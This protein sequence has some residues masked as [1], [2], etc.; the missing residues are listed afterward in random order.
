M[1]VKKIYPRLIKPPQSSFFLFGP[2]GIGKSTWAKGQFLGAHQFDLL[3]EGLYQ[4]LLG[5]PS[6]FGAELSTLPQQSWVIVDEIQRLP[7]LLNLV[8]LY[9]EER[10]LQFILLGSSARN[11]KTAGTN[12]L[13]GRAL[14]KMMFPL[15]PEEL[16]DDFSLEEIF[17]F[18]AIPL[19]W[20][21]PS[22]AETLKSY[23]QLYLKEEIQA[24]ALVRNLPGFTRFLSIAA[25]F[26]G[27]LINIAGIAR[28]SGTAR[29]TVSGFLDILDDTLLTF[30]LPAFV[31]KLKVREKKHP[32]LYWV[33][34]GLV[35]AIK[36]QLGP[37]AL[38]ERGPLLE[39][40]ILGLLRVYGEE[41]N[42][43][44]EIYYWSSAHATGHEVDFLLQRD[45]EYLAI[46]VKSS[47]KY[48]TKFLSGLRAIQDLPG[49]K[50]RILIYCGDR[51][52]KSDDG[53]DIL[54][55]PAFCNALLRDA[56]WK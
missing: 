5:N 35:R 15:T 56:L 28:D 41:S 30:R 19:V 2:R 16:E 45:N 31:G 43:F 51:N 52:L 48:N 32:K 7:S 23:V 37:L 18:G 49:L 50:R 9:M 10:G 13:A 46:E 24:E 40:W 4:N 22:K 55:V 54:T 26:H 53:I 20:Q 21:S 11:L 14:K 33:D 29:T 39:G 25:L 12:L 44:H 27:A 8:H 34:P 1:V 38:E 17:R 36:K 3:D 47:S 6:L 42:L